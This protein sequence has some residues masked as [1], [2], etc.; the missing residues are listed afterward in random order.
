MLGV[1]QSRKRVPA[2]GKG[3]RCAQ[4]DIISRVERASVDLLYDVYNVVIRI[5]NA[6]FI[7]EI[8]ALH[9]K[10]GILPAD[11][12]R[13]IVNYGD[14]SACRVCGRIARRV[15]RLH[16]VLQG[17]PRSRYHFRKRAR[18]GILNL[19]PR[20]AVCASLENIGQRVA[21]R[22]GRRRARNIDILP[23]VTLLRRCNAG[24]RGRRGVVD[25]FIIPA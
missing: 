3:K 8:L 11:N 20:S 21:V 6:V 25:D 1:C 23:A 18:G 17:I 14:R 13:L 12:G 2:Y 15:N 24:R 19:C 4:R 22:I 16:A 10:I 5:G 9:A 7:G